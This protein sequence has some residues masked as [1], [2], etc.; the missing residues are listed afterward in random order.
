MTL[1]VSP[2]TI[3]LG[4]TAAL[5]AHVQP[6]ECGGPATIHYVATE[7]SISGD[8]FVSSGIQVAPSQAEGMKTVVVTATATDSRGMTA[9]AS[10]TIRVA[11]PPVLRSI[12]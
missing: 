10:A 5:R 8:T 2:T 4:S 6:S 3:L 9:T 11:I 1:E 12:R 7:G